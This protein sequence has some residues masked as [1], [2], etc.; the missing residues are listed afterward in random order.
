MKNYPEHST[1]G[2]GEWGGRWGGMV[3]L[4]KYTGVYGGEER[5]LRRGNCFVPIYEK[6]LCLRRINV[7]LQY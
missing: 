5:K 1:A 3:K 7:V 2:G 6:T 4:G